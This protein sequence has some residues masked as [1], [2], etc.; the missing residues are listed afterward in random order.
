MLPMEVLHQIAKWLQKDKTSLAP[1]TSV[2][3]FWRAAF[4]P[5]VYRSIC[6]YSDDEYKQE[7]QRGVSLESF[8][9]L[10]SGDRAIRRTWIRDLEYSILIPYELSDWTTRKTGNAEAYSVDNPVRKANDLAFQQAM[11][12]LFQELH[13]WNQT[14]RL[15]LD[16]VIRGRRVD[17]APEP[18]TEYYWAARDYN[19]KYPDGRRFFTPPYRAQFVQPMPDLVSIP[20]IEKLSFPNENWP[21][22]R[23]H[24]IWP[25]AIQTIIQCC[26]TISELALNLDEWVRPD[27][28]E[29]IQ[30]RRTA[31]G[32]LIESI[33]KS[34]RVLDYDGPGDDNWK[35]TLPQLNLIPSGVDSVSVNLRDLSV[36]L[37]ELR[38]KRSAIEYDFLYPLDRDGK[39]EPSSL[40]WPHLEI[41]EIEYVRPWLPSGE[42]VYSYTAE[43]QAMIDE[44]D[45][46]DME[47]SDPER[48]WDRPSEMIDEH[49][50]RVFISMGYAAQHMPR[51][52]FLNFE[53]DTRY[54][55]Y[56][57]FQ[58][59]ADKT[60][61]VWGRYP[62]L[63]PDERGLKAW[64]IDPD[65]LKLDIEDKDNTSVVLKNWPPQSY[66]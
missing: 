43:D 20:C 36:Q 54:P 23:H 64:N 28:L 33:P 58:K 26:P 25:E 21:G 49:F 2:C 46:W 27:H 63:R 59:I 32:S 56:L 17:P 48:G 35:F 57:Y 41:L 15:E 50:H 29:F 18:H 66:T 22:G 13:L 30:A 10:T 34:L 37:R 55:F 61:L 9:K 65:D 31:S 7:G 11:V 3:R 14:L 53:N 38:F 52:K 12:D 47:L 19:P 16:L 8:R 5:L 44:I 60:T 39:P 40:H 1:C 42:S 45:D 6:V 24:Q 4:E 51:L 62:I